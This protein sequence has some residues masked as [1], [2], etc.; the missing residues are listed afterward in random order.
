M[1]DIKGLFLSPL[2]YFLGSIPFAFIFTYLFKQKKIY[3]EGTGNVG[4]A[5]TFQEAGLLPGFLT[6]FGEI[7]KAV[8]PILI[9]YFFFDKDFV[10]ALLF[11]YLSLLGTNFSIFLRGKG[12]MGSTIIIYSLVLFSLFDLSSLWTLLSMG[13]AFLI[14]YI[15]TRNSTWTNRIAYAT[16]PFLAYAYSSNF[17]FAGWG[18]L[19][20]ILY[21]ARYRESKDEAALSKTRGMGIKNPFLRQTELFYP[22]SKK[23]A[24]FGIGNK[25]MNLLKLKENDFKIPETYVIPCY[26]FDEYKKGNEE[27]TEKLALEIQQKLPVEECC[28]SIRSSANIEDTSQ[29]S[30]AGQFR[31]YLN[32]V[33]IDSIIEKVELIW[34]SF[35]TKLSESYSDGI[36][37]SMTKSRMS[38][39]IQ[40]M[41]DPVYSGVIF[42]KNPV[43]GLDEIIIEYVE[44]LG[45][46]L[47]QGI[48]TPERWINKWGQWI[49]QPKSDSEN[50]E[51][52]EKLLYEAKKISKL[53]GKP[54][55]LEWAFDGSEIYWLQAREITTLQHNRLYSNKI[56]KE[57]LPGI[58]KPLIWSINIPVVNTSWKNLFK[59]LIGYPARKIE[60]ENL[61]KSFYYRAYFNMGVIGDILELLGMPREL[62][63]QLAGIEVSESDGP[64]FKPS[65]KTI[66]YLPRMLIFIMRKILYSISIRRYLRTKYKAFKKIKEINLSDKD[67]E[68]LFNKIDSIFNYSTKGSYVVILS[69]LLN[70]FYTM[71]LKRQL[72]KEKIEFENLDL[73]DAKSNLL[74]ID[75]R[76]R[77]ERLHH[78]YHL[79]TENDKAIMTSSNFIENIHE[80]ENEE[81]KMELQVFL[82][83]FGHN[84]DSGNDFSQPS[85]TETPEAIFYLIK[86]FGEAK[87]K[88]EPLTKKPRFR[89]LLTRIFYR[90]SKKYHLYRDQVGYVYQY[91]YSLFRPYFLR[92]GEKFLDSNLIE[93][94]NDIFYLKYDEII[95]LAN[96]KKLAA[97]MRK[98]IANRKNEIEKY[99]DIV[100]PDLIFDD[101]APDPIISGAKSKTLFGVATSKGTYTG[102][103]KIIKGRSDFKKVK[104]GDIIIIPF[105]D[106]S[107]TPLFNKA[108]AVISESGGMLSHCSIVAREFKIPAIVSVRNAMKI[109]DNSKLSV[110]GFTGKITLLESKEDL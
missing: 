44:G 57:F 75:S 69:Q 29:F 105:S 99:K 93:V 82:H 24:R 54:I 35:D 56:S 43:T 3:E 90:Q 39:I 4:V 41:V 65:M 59:E 106:V 62:L 7:S 60:V 72:K 1:T 76:F 102:K 61:A 20:A 80:L 40:E 84:R 49:E 95:S 37:T 16:L 5:N 87:T 92:V 79:L 18:L 21:I 38:V 42:T 97:K 50:L 10:L 30:F 19:V 2:F 86:N 53:Y 67:Y 104:E 26:A 74:N 48:I 64:K 52:M 32:V 103:A 85:W 28:F 9:A 108:K 46:K 23:S 91:G 89:K 15:I 77:L 100:L 71:M 33:G 68:F 34:K 6:V 51:L 8:V 55:D 14:A 11:T 36:A 96:D 83:Y 66:R 109:K 27:I 25:S 101:I 73:L 47:V 17:Y 88:S 58:I 107:W 31:T 63:E 13:A 12:G 110:D 78:L 70:S 98:I 94:R 45:D 81:F 22:L